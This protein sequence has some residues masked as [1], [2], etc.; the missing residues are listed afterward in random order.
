[1]SGVEMVQN[2]QRSVELVVPNRLSY[3]SAAKYAECGEKWR[4]TYGRG[5]TEGSWYASVAGSTIHH[6]TELNDRLRLAV[7]RAVET[8]YD[9]T[10]ALPVPRP[11]PTFKEEFLRRIAEEEAAGVKLK[12]SG[13]KTEEIGWTGGP[14]KKDIAWWLHYGPQYVQQWEVWRDEHTDLEILMLDG[15]EGPGTVPAIELEFYVKIGEEWVRGYVDRVFRDK[16]TGDIIIVDIKSGKTPPG[17]L[18]LGDYGVGLREAFGIKADYGCY[19]IVW[20]RANI[21]AKTEIRDVPVLLEDGSPYLYKTGA[22][23]GEPKT[24]KETV[25]LEEGRP[26]GLASKLT[27]PVDLRLYSKEFMVARY[28]MA[29]DG[30]MAGVFMPNV[31]S[32]C[33]S[34]G[35]K[36]FCRAYGGEQAVRFPVRE[37]FIRAKEKEV[38]EEVEDGLTDVE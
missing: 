21:P 1:M 15:P 20:N 30:I 33:N 14:N 16:V 4:L 18:Q 13:K 23:K 31:T 35:V 19:W 28:E 22:R 11:A 6:I 29:R 27:D 2:R 37:L 26:G 25:V 38:K 36:K 10:T 32:M 34:C 8:D 9:P 7:G 24:I 17:Q 3:S 12:A 5:V